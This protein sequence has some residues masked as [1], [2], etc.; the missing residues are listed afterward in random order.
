MTDQEKLAHL[1]N[2]I[3]EAAEQVVLMPVNRNLGGQNMVPGRLI[4]DIAVA[5]PVPIW[6]AILVALDAE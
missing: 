6:D 3:N 1:R 4:P 2:R 5:L